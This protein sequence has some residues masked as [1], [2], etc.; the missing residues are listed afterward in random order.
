MRFSLI[1]ATYGRTEVLGRFLTSLTKQTYRD[2]ELIVV[3]QN[4]DDRL[5]PIL[6]PYLG[7]IAMS[8]LKSQPGLSRARNHGIEH[9]T[10]D[11]YTFP[12]DDCWY[13]P[14]L[15]ANVLHKLM[16]E[17]ERAGLAGVA[18]DEEGRSAVGRR[19]TL[20][21]PVTIYRAWI[22]CTSVAM[23]FKREV[24]EAVGG[25]DDTLGAGSGTMW[26]S[27][28]DVDYCI[29]AIK[30]GFRLHYDPHL[31]VRH[32]ATTQD[33]GMIPLEKVQGYASGMGRVLRKQQYPAWFVA[34]YCLRSF[35]GMLANVVSGRGYLA[36]F[37]A[38]TL[39]GRVAGWLTKP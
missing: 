9:A 12:D 20:A 37:H 10:G 39:K 2:F 23:F 8:H 14:D 15:L 28:E 7:K 16:Q 13:D 33:S 5:L 31:V 34:Y 38:Y 17:P 26:G 6:S 11:V 32:P 22:Q 29:R 4:P 21:E 3:D 35:A 27:A 30:K 18:A 1:L 25:F 36:R 19:S 24:V